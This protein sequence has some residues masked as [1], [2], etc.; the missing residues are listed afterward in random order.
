MPDR[1]EQQGLVE[2]LRR[3]IPRAGENS[4]GLRNEAATRIEQLEAELARARETIQ[5]VQ[6]ALA[7][8]P[9]ADTA[10]RDRSIAADLNAGMSLRE[11]ARKHGVGVGVIRGVK[12]KETQHGR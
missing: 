1:I 10:E 11:C 6:G 12:A 3:N 4:S 5:R 9:P 2:R 7:Y 8:I